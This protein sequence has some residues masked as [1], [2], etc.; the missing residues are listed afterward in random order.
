MT[1]VSSA[2]SVYAAHSLG[3]SGE[4]LS[5]GV[6]RYPELCWAG[7]L[8]R[9]PLLPSDLLAVFP[10]FF[11]CCLL[12]DTYVYPVF[13]GTLGWGGAACAPLVN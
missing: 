7:A 2:S 3:R 4:V 8:Q 10:R 6:S 13:A 5:R 12:V 9:G 1:L 11:R